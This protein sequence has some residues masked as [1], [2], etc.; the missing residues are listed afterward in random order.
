MQCSKQSYF[1]K[2]HLAYWPQKIENRR[3]YTES[4]LLFCNSL[5]VKLLMQAEPKT[6][7]KSKQKSVQLVIWTGMRKMMSKNQFFLLFMVFQV[8]SKSRSKNKPKAK[9]KIQVVQ[10]Q[11]ERLW[12]V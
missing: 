6:N 11:H 7:R 8:V 5:F 3:K 2:Y 4:K 10:K 1:G 12:L 9:T